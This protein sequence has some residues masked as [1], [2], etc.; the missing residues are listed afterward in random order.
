MNRIFIRL[1]S[2]ALTVAALVASVPSRAHAV[3]EFGTR[4]QK[5]FQN[6]WQKT[7]PYM[8]AR[9]GGFNDELDDTDTKL[10][11]FD[12]TG[13]G[14]G[15]TYNDGSVPA[16]GVDTG[17]LF[18]V[19]THGGAKSSQTSA[20]LAMWQENLRTYSVDWRFGNNADGAR[21][22]SQ[23]ACETLW[24]DDY[25]YDRWDQVFKG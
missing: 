24:L 18:Y 9:C 16:G 10:F 7:L 11:Y 22:F 17:D 4:C 12:L 8:Y 1:T 19:S 6:G 20:R 13:V 25:S 14:S 21:I 5:S 2:V 15:F 23:Y 3:A